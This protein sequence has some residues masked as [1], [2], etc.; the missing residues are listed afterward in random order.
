VLSA[1]IAYEA[2]RF[3]DARDRVRHSVEPEPVHD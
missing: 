2:L 3:A 1:L